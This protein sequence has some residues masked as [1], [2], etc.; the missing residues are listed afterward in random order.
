[1][2]RSQA[3]WVRRGEAAASL[4]LV[5]NARNGIGLFDADANIIRGNR[6][7]LNGLDGVRAEAQARP[8]SVS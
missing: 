4:R 5:R 8:V 3:A 1:M 2:A 7:E 6:A